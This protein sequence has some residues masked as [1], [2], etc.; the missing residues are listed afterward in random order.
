MDKE[1]TRHA[2]LEIL[3]VLDE[4]EAIKEHKGEKSEKKNIGKCPL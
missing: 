2:V 4:S 3:K 1:K